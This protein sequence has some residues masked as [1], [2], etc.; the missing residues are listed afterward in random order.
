M[1]PTKVQAKLAF[2]DKGGEETNFVID[3]IICIDCGI[4]CIPDLPITVYCCIHVKRVGDSWLI[5]CISVANSREFFSNT[6][7]TSAF[8]PMARQL[9][10]HL[11]H[12]SGRPPDV[13]Q[14][15]AHRAQ[16]F[17]VISSPNCSRS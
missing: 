8:M 10:Y 4:L 7:Q 15:D 13:G 6:P 5:G 2:N 12:I 3:V 9:F 17:H 1:L 11:G 14:E 16:N